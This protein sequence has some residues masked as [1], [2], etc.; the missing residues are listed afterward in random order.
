M[1]QDFLVGRWH[2]LPL[3]KIDEMVIHDSAARRLIH[4]CQHPTLVPQTSSYAQIHQPLLSCLV[5]SIPL[6]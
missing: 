4:T 3:P 5:L 2:L 6:D 1:S